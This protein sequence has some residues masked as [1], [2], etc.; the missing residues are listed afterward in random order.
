MTIRDT[1]PL[2]ANKSLHMVEVNN[3]ILLLGVTDHNIVCLQEYD[4]EALLTELRRLNDHGENN[5]PPSF[6]NIFH[7]Q[8]DAL[9]RLTGRVPGDREER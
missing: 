1:V 9:Q 5:P 2:G 7:Q 4:D 3:K 8:I 6:Q